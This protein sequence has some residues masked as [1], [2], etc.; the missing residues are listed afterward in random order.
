MKPADRKMIIIGLDGLDPV[1]V[2]R[3]IAAGR[4]PNL[5]KLAEKGTLSRM[6]TS[7]PPQSP[8]A[9]SCLISGGNPGE[10]D[11]FDFIVRDPATNLPEM[12]MTE[13]KKSKSLLKEVFAGLTGPAVETRRKGNAFWD[14]LGRAGVKSVIMRMPVTFPAQPME[15]R[16]L[17]GMGTPDI[18][19]TQG[20][21]TYFTTGDATEETRGRLVGVAW[22][23]GVIETEVT[24]PRLQSLSGNRNVVIP[25][26]VT[27][28]SDK[29][30]HVSVDGKEFELRVGE[31]SPWIRLR[32][33]AGIMN[34]VRGIVRFHLNAVLP[35]FRL[36]MTPV[37]IDPQAPAMQI[38]YPTDYAKE[39]FEKIGNYYT[40]GMPYDTW[41]LNE[42]RLTEQQFLEQAYS[43]LDENDRMMR[44]ELDRFDKGLL[45][46]YFGITDLVQHMF[47]RYIDPGTPAP[48]SSHD[49]AIRDAISNVYHRIDAVIGEAME[50]A[51]PDTAIV[52]LSDHGFGAFRRA[53]HV[54]SWLRDNG[55][56]VLKDGDVEGQEFFT[57]V[58]WQQTRAY[59]VGFGGIYINQVGR[60]KYGVVYKGA[61]TTEVMKEI[62]DGL[63]KWKDGE[64]DIV[65]HVYLHD[66][67]YHGPHAADGPDLFIGFNQPYR[68]SWQSGLGAAPRGLV[69]DNTRMWA[70]DHLCD[71]SLVPGVLASNL[72]MKTEGASL[73]D[74]SPTVLTY[75]GVAV[76]T[77]AEGHSLLPDDRR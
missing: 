13:P 48:A 31:W 24:G 20:V 62:A 75:F 59:S 72:K 9:W 77:A 28:R 68:A 10:H 34:E 3:Y 63:R 27:K 70:G 40:Q 47:W 73:L 42:G 5:K 37:N 64:H 51:G 2:D 67:L 52:V 45:F 49:P 60:E 44:M 4:M 54:N 15:G 36:Y 23:D 66:E 19:G 35:D 6:A 29:E 53:A 38:S 32:F 57:N 55:F 61:E 58:D 69:E 12:G 46:C 71:P 17:S 74:I 30:I 1:L 50:K 76:S 26:K 11:V 16:L 18:R 56:L 65:R 22:K 8:V 39:I 43:I 21:F 33:K 14:L 41:A 25:M 7:N